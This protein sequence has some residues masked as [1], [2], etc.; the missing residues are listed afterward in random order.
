MAEKTEGF[1]VAQLNE[2]YTSAALQ[3]HYDKAINIESLVESLEA[4]NEKTRKRE[5][6]ID[7]YPARV[8][9]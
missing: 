4:A 5:W 3:W 6:E 8:G 9:F 7:D 2:L 1:S